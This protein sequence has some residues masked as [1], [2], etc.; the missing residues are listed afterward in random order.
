MHL[1]DRGPRQAP[2]ELPAES[3]ACHGPAA[4]TRD[5]P[6][7]RSHTDLAGDRRGRL[8]INR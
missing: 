2:A 1:R 4:D 8:D 6:L 7:T 3:P 5:V